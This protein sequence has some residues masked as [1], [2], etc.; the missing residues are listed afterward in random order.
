MDFEKRAQ[1]LV[2]ALPYIQSY[3]GKTVVVKYGGSAMVDPALQAA[4][5]QDIVLLAQVGVKV[6]LVHG[7]GKEISDTLS[8]L[9]IPTE[10]VGGRRKTDRATMDVVQMVLCG[11]VNKDLVNLIER[12]GGTALGLSGLDGRMLTVKQID[13]S[14]GFVG[15]VVSVNVNVITDAL[16]SG[17]IPVISTVGCDV[18]GNSYNVNADDAAGV[19]AAALGA[20]CFV[21][22]TDMRGLLRDTSDPNSLISSLTIDEAFALIRDKVVCGGMIPKIESVAASIKGGVNRVFIVDGRVPHSL[23]I[24]LLSDAGI[25]TMFT[26]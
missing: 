3:N 8:R 5:M 13:E 26:K 20:D 18:A 2:E 6:V 4:V 15:E 19:I 12:T 24:E 16:A 7:G 1:V 10:F 17:Y 11:K 22:L 25:G 9:N 23:L 14:L 21:S